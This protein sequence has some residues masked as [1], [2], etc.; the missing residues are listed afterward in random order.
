MF[1]RF[2]RAWIA[3]LQRPGCFGVIDKP[4]SSS[5]DLTQELIELCWR[6]HFIRQLLIEHFVRQ[7]AQTLAK[8]EQPADAIGFVVG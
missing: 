2:A 5:V 8:P 7:V 3:L 6:D 1:H 4:D